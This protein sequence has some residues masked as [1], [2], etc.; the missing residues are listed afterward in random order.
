MVRTWPLSQAKSPRISRRIVT[1]RQRSIHFCPACY[2][3]R[4]GETTMSKSKT[5]LI[6]GANRGIGLG[7]TEQLL[8]KGYDVIATARHPDGSRE[9]WEA[10]RDYG[11][12]CEIHELDVTSDKDLD[13]LAKALGGRPIDL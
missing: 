4:G 3:R 9:L 1:N 11:K 7:L 10:E 5:A 6:T 12:R 13:K 2:I 8:A